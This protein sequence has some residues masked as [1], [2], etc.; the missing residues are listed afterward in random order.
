[1][2]DHIR[3]AGQRIAELIDFTGRISRTKEG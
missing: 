3:A 1:M 2:E